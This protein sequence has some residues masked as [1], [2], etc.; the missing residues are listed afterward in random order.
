MT[1]GRASR[2]GDTRVSPNGYHYTRTA[3]GWELT[4]RLIAEETLGRPL[5]DN[6]RVKFKDND[7]T[8]LYRDNIEVYVVKEQSKKKRIAVLEHR[9]QELQA[10]LEDLY[11]D[12]S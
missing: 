4:H 9:I 12:V 3:K 10:E 8:N 5:A 2:I 6:E 1:R 11:E 7:R